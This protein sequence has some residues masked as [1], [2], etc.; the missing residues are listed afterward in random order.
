MQNALKHVGHLL[1]WENGFRSD[2]NACFK[3]WEEKEEFLVA[4][5]EILHKHNVRDNSWLQ[6][7]FEVKEK[8]AK[9][10]AEI[11]FSTGMTSS[12]LSES[13]NAYMKDYLQLDYDIVK[14]FSHFEGLLNDKRY[15]ELWA[16]YNLRQKLSK[17]KMSSPMLIQVTNIYTSQ[18]FFKFQKQ[19]EEF[20]RAYIK[21]HIKRI[22]FHEYLVS[23]Y[24]KPKDRR[25]I[26]NSLENDFSC[27]CRKFER[28]EIL[29]GHALKILDIMNIKVLPE[30]YILKRWTKD[31]RNEIVQDFNGHEII[32]DT[33]LKVTNRYKSLRPLYVKLISRAVECEET[34][35][36]T[37]ENYNDLSKKIEDVVK[38]KS[39]IC[40]VDNS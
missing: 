40:Q 14:F 17:I 31:P 13:L 34:Y 5:D 36:I 12:Q 8:L 21:E 39:D 26:W 4:W 28:C 1:R 15:K 18:P 9:A 19:Y 11:S 22:S 30:K 37:L 7:L 33:N 35:K 6:R 38:R 20:Q 29:C 24:D 10:Y 27:S 25:V 16:E 2:L 23:M 32:I 3:V